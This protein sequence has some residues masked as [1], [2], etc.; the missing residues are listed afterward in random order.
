MT[1]GIICHTLMRIYIKQIGT[2]RGIT[3]GIFIDWGYDD[4]SDDDS[5]N[6][7]NN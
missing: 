5:V 6:Y 4:Y 3:V 2:R 7:V 1:I